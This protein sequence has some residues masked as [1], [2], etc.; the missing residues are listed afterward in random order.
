MIDT[1]L[2]AE[3]LGDETGE[4]ETMSTLN[5][6]IALFS[7]MLFVVVAMGLHSLQ[8]WLEA[9]SDNWRK[10]S[11]VVTFARFRQRAEVSL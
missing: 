6:L 3:T 11:G 4:T 7:F 8:M 5:A 1:L 10:I 2:T 9:D